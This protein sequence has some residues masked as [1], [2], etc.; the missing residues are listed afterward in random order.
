VHQTYYNAKIK[1]LEILSKTTN[2]NTLSQNNQSKVNQ[3]VDN[4]M[5]CGGKPDLCVY[6]KNSLYNFIINFAIKYI[7]LILVDYD[8]IYIA[9]EVDTKEGKKVVLYGLCNRLIISDLERVPKILILSKTLMWRLPIKIDLKNPCE[10]TKNKNNKLMLSPVKNQMKQN[11]YIPSPV[12]STTNNTNNTNNKN[13]IKQNTLQKSLISPQSILSINEYCPDIPNLDEV[14]AKF[15]RMLI[16]NKALGYKCPSIQEKSLDPK[17]QKLL[18]NPEVTEMNAGK[19]WEQFVKN[20][21]LF[22]K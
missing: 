17:T 7:N 4:L 15:V 10:A 13:T 16:A 1:L 11:I 9:L 6:F 3:I 21:A 18:N 2:S 19:L 12:K 8:D 20:Y 22:G 5:K 14:C